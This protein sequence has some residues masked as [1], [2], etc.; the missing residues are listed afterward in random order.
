[1]VKS[2]DTIL[3]LSSSIELRAKLKRA[4]YYS[5]K[6]WFGL[7]DYELEYQENTVSRVVSDSYV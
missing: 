3:G 5:T 6:G 4:I 7:K 2:L 1:L